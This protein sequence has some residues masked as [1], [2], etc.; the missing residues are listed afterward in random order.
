M[1][2]PNKEVREL[3]RKCTRLGLQVERLNGGH[4]RF[5]RPDTTDTVVISG[6]TVGPRAW[7]SNRSRLRRVFGVEV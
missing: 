3:I 6:T 2:A 7:Q 4:F 1:K 5:F